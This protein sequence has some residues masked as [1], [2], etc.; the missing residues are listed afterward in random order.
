MAR[1]DA[2]KKEETA[3]RQQPQEKILK[4]TK[5]VTGDSLKSPHS[6][7]VQRRSALSLTICLG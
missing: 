6:L 4:E 7:K 3:Q 1:S 2:E 5:P